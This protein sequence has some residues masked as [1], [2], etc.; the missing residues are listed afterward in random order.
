MPTPGLAGARADKKVE[1]NQGA[2]KVAQQRRRGRLPCPATKSVSQQ[3]RGRG[4]TPPTPGVSA[5]GREA[6]VKLGKSKGAVQACVCSGA[7]G[8]WGA[9]G[10]RL[11]SLA[12]RQLVDEVAVGDFV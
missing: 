2:Q 10:G 6:A 8:E 4:R 12:N 3:W 11:G 9:V 7:V 1:A 5:K